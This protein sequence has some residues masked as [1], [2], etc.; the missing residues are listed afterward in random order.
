MLAGVLAAEGVLVE[1]EEVV[2]GG[3]EWQMK[4]KT[5]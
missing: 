3:G 1:V 2:V 5:K 4:V